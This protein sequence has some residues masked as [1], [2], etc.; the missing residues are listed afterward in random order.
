MGKCSQLFT[1]VGS[2]PLDNYMYI[3]T[4]CISYAHNPDWLPQYYRTLSTRHLLS[5][6]CTKGYSTVSIHLSVRT[7]TLSQQITIDPAARRQRIK[8]WLYTSGCSGVLKHACTCII[9][10][11]VRV[12]A[13]VG[14]AKFEVV[15]SYLIDSLALA[16]YSG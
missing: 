16:S 1:R 4:V 14:E 12:H 8:I 2:L 9:L 5:A 7:T 6:L 10:T 11:L 3:G 13:L 15:F